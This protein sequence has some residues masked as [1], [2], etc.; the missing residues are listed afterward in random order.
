ESA[1][2][3]AFQIARQGHRDAAARP[4]LLDTCH[5]QPQ[6]ERQARPAD[7]F[8][9]VVVHLRHRP[10]VGPPLGIAGQVDE[11]R[12]HRVRGRR[13][14]PRRA[15]LVA[16]QRHAPIM[17]AGPGS[18]LSSWPSTRGVPAPGVSASGCQLTVR[19]RYVSALPRISPEF[20]GTYEPERMSDHHHAHPHAHP[21][22]HT[23]A[24]PHTHGTGSDPAEL[25]PSAD[26]SVPD[27]ELSPAE[28]SRRSMLRG[29]GLLGAGLAAGNVLATPQAAAKAETGSAYRGGLQWLAGDHHIHTQYSNDGKYR[30]IDQVRHGNAYGLDWMV[31]TDHGNVTHAKIGV[32]KVNP[33]IVAA[34][35]SVRGT[36]VFQGLEWNIPAAEHGTVFVHPG[37]NEVD[38]LKEFENSYDGKVADAED[39]TPQNEALAIAGVNFLSD[40]VKSKRLQDALFLA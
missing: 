17:S 13:Q 10:D 34:R 37:R 28:L 24:H 5:P 19:G 22:P 38:V 40:A 25:P 26:L 36:L 2:E 30:V 16:V 29:A 31:I 39:S 9:G 3:H 23:H 1:A 8:S 11:R 7:E 20:T 15:G 12:E 6:G 18:R 27:T 32:E 33:D 35:E 14:R 4:V 21:H